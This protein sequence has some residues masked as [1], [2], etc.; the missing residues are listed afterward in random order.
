[1]LPVRNGRSHGDAFIIKVGFELFAAAAFIFLHSNT[2]PPPLQFS[3]VLQ[4]VQALR[5][6]T[7]M[8]VHATADGKREMNCDGTQVLYLQRITA[9][10]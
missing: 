10:A 1:M 2:L 3:S 8:L 5:E 6:Q 9:L 7:L 4:N